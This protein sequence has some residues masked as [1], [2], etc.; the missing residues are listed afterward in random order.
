MTNDAS[1]SSA[2]D[3]LSKS[4]VSVKLAA[5]DIAMF[6]ENPAKYTVTDLVSYFESIHEALERFIARNE[7]AEGSF[8][9]RSLQLTDASQLAIPAHPD[10]DRAWTPIEV[11]AIGESLDAAYREGIRV[12]SQPKPVL[13]SFRVIVNEAG[14]QT[15]LAFDCQAETEEAAKHLAQKQYPS[16]EIVS[17]EPF[18]ETS[19][20][21]HEWEDFVARFKPETNPNND[22]YDGFMF[23]TFGEDHAKVREACD[24][25]PGHIWTLL[26]CDGSM[27]VANGMHFVNRMGYFI[28]EVPYTGKDCEFVDSED[29]T[30]D[31]SDQDGEQNTE[32][33]EQNARPA[34]RD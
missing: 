34:P 7:A 17:V 2:A 31:E 21:P 12:G 5:N 25:N 9:G 26:D 20:P 3:A 30:E 11:S 6:L 18:S 33:D 29:I 32:H 8:E 19:T 14:S 13:Q 27:V 1:P 4:I 24:Q 23:E 15:K 28:C 10:G 22:S 16:A